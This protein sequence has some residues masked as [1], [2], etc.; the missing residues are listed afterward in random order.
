MGTASPRIVVMTGAETG[1]GAA[2]AVRFAAQGGH[3]VPLGRRQAPLD[4]V[5]AHTRGLAL[6]GDAASARPG[7]A[8][9]TDPPALRPDRRADRMRRRARTRPRYASVAPASGSVAPPSTTIVCPVT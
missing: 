3:V 7:Q 6:A 9:R 2:C 8:S 4:A 1:I 5:A